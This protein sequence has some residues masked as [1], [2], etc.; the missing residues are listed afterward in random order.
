LGISSRGRCL[1]S[2]EKDYR[3]HIPILAHAGNSVSRLALDFDHG[4]AL[5]FGLDNISFVT[6]VVFLLSY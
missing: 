3:K 5:D 2:T 4:S 6:L 1:W